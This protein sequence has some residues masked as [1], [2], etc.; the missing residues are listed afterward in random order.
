V[1]WAKTDAGRLEMQARALV[2]ERAT[3]NLL[4]L[5]DGVKSEEMLLANLAGISRDDLMLL[6]SLG[7]IAPLGTTPATAPSFST[8][9]ATGASAAVSTSASPPAAAA[10]APLDYAQFTAELTQ[11]ISRDLGLRGL[12]LT[13]AVE[14][15]ATIEELQD[16][17]RRVLDQVRER[18]G[19]ALATA[20]RRRL[21]G[22]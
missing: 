14:K 3:R 22:A 9:T 8:A 2:K 13:L 10:N 18:K 11:I 5:I 15:A 17:A 6:Q 12:M 19:E 1:I 21:Y 4:L 7:L 16:V 20:A